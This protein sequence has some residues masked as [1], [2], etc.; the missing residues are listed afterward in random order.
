MHNRT[1]SNKG[2]TFIGV[3]VSLSLLLGFATMMLTTTRFFNKNQV[4]IRMAT[5]LKQESR[6]KVLELYEENNW[7]NLGNEIIVS[8]VG[9][10]KVEYDYQ[11]SANPY[12]T[13]TLKVTFL[14]DEFQEE[15]TIERSVAHVK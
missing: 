9:D 4:E 15:Y 6:N 13:N 8:P 1:E 3:L 14:L 10:I 5:N 2:V 12:Q 11:G 7:E